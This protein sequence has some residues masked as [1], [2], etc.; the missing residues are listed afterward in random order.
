MQAVG[1]AA[2]AVVGAGAGTTTAW[3]GF[4]A[5]AGAACATMGVDNLNTGF[6][7]MFSGEDRATNFN[8][9]FQN[10]GFSPEASSYINIAMDFGSTL[11]AGSATAFS[12]GAFAK[13]P[14]AFASSSAAE[15]LTSVGRW[16]SEKEYNLMRQTGKVQES[17][18]L[19]TTYVANPANTGAFMLQAKP[20]SF[21]VEFDILSSS[22]KSTRNSWA[23]ILG[24]NSVEGRFAAKNGLEIP[25]MPE[26]SNIIHGATKIK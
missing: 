1:G 12:Q 11:G 15:D 16:M 6:Q 7:K 25:K 21:Y 13:A 20:G 22:L 18:Y 26:A 8:Q 3:T 14:G 19:G 4:G 10:S 2:Q 17:K 24:P 23:K 5:A 9:A